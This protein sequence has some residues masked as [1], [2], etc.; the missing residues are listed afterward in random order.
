MLDYFINKASAFE[1][2][3]FVTVVGMAGVF[4][5]LILFYLFIKILTRII[6]D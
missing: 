2:G 4:L 6:P 1:Q 5:A 3:L